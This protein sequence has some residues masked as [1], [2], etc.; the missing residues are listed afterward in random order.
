MGMG[1]MAAVMMIMMAFVCTCT[2]KGE[3]RRRR[4]RRRNQKA[5]WRW[6][7]GAQEPWSP[8]FLLCSLQQVRTGKSDLTQV[9]TNKGTRR[10]GKETPDPKMDIS[11]DSHNQC[12]VN[13]MYVTIIVCC[14]IANKWPIRNRVTLSL[15]LLLAVPVYLAGG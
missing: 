14:S 8:S 6:S 9:R 7:P 12:Q 4:R 11:P 3:R 2:R 5:G 10:Q 13:M 1:V 15:L